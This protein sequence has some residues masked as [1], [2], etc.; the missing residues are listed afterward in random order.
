MNCNFIIIGPDPVQ[1]FPAFVRGLQ[2]WQATVSPDQLDHMS[3]YQW[4]TNN[5]RFNGVGAYT[6]NEFLQEWYRISKMDPAKPVSSVVNDELLFGS[7]AILLVEHITRFA[8]NERIS[9]IYNGPPS[10]SHPVIYREWTYLFRITTYRNER[11]NT[12]RVPGSQK[13]IYHRGPLGEDSR[14]VPLD[15]APIRFSEQALN[16]G[17]HTYMSKKDKNTL[18]QQRPEYNIHLVS[19]NERDSFIKRTAHETQAKPSA[20]TQKRNRPNRRNRR[21]FQ[22]RTDL[23]GFFEAVFARYQKRLAG[24]PPSL[25]LSFP[26]Y[27]EVAPL[28]ALHGVV[29][30]KE[31]LEERQKKLEKATTYSKERANKRKREKID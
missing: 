25:N 19:E 5:L 26:V 9:C 12:N 11:A 14:M 20:T 30:P 28:T 1:Q 2:N 4:V 16:V 21:K 29:A 18:C 23:Q 17:P 15:R 27:T 6:A 13:T 7:F 31:M 22:L 8:S 3:L 24:E 10:P